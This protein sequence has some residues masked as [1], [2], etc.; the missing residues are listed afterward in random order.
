M[1]ERQVDDKQPSEERL[2][3]WL[4]GEL[5]PAEA[6]AV[7]QWLD[8]H[9]E[10]AA[11]V[12]RWAT[13][14]ATLR[15]KLDAQLDE[16]LP[17]SLVQTVRQGSRA[18]TEAGVAPR[19]GVGPWGFG[20]AL[21]ASFVAGVALSL[22]LG[23]LRPQAGAASPVAQAGGW[24]Q[25]ALVAHAVYVPEQ[26]HPV[27]VSTR[28]AEGAEAAQE[29]H[30]KAWLT[31]RLGRPVGLFDLR[32]PGYSLIGGRLLPGDAG[33]SAQL[34]YEDAAGRRVTV[35]LQVPPEREARAD[36]H[37]QFRYVEREGL[38]QFYWVEG[39]GGQALGYAL[40]GAL[41][42]AD[43]LALAERIDRQIMAGR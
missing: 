25:R 9:P 22:T 26:R 21:A 4:D 15:A 41:P 14:R 33:P 37:A 42:R 12:Q 5:P 20:L 2:S 31:K 43:L 40:V 39:E 27:E 17:E 11:R 13:D 1:D 16:P 38:G 34:M 10:V 23:G 7:A 19:R 35:Y 29:Q 6:Q 24:T 30:L 36:G 32:D 28:G 18:A 8:G 3:A